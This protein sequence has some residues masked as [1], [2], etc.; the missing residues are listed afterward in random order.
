MKIMMRAIENQVSMV[1]NFSLSA[2][3]LLARE[4]P[5]VMKMILVIMHVMWMYLKKVPTNGLLI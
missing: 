4:E 3:R 5:R 2:D 1:L